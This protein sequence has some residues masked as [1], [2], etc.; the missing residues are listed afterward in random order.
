MNDIKV[1]NS[2]YSKYRLIGI[3][4]CNAQDCKYRLDRIKILPLM[5]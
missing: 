5:T 3:K 1:C 4:V 2:Q